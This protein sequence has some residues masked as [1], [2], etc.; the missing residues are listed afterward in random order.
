M[1]I[2]I[3]AKPNAKVTRCTGKADERTFTVAL[4]APAT[5]GKANEELIAFL[6]DVLD[7]P[8]S[9]ITVVRGLTSKTKHVE[10][11]DTIDLSKLHE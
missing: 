10:I 9:T 2:T 1:I 11:P 6:S 8:K 3:N 5:E 7:V 4:H